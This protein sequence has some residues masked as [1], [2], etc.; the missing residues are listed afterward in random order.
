MNFDTLSRI[1]PKRFPITNNPST[2]DVSSRR[3]KRRRRKRTC[4]APSLTVR[5]S[6]RSLL[7]F[8]SFP[9]PSFIF[10]K[11]RRRNTEFRRPECRH[12]ILKNLR[13][14]RAQGRPAQVYRGFSVTSEFPNNQPKE[15]L[16]ESFPLSREATIA[17]FFFFPF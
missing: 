8:L 14:S 17:A 10:L 9:I 1:S 3:S 15:K 13:Y 11:V 5:S 12:S 4:S 7:A 6:V 16:A 2:R